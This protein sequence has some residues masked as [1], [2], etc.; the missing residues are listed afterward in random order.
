MDPKHA[1]RHNTN[2]IVYMLAEKKDLKCLLYLCQEVYLEAR[3]L[4]GFRLTVV[5]IVPHR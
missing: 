3:C 4:V 1:K 5:Q 2:N